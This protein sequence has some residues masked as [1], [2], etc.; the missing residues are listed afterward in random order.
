MPRHMNM[1]LIG[2][3]SCFVQGEV[4]LCGGPDFQTEV[5]KI[6]LAVTVSRFVH[7]NRSH[8]FRLSCKKFPIES[9]EELD[10][11]SGD[12]DTKNQIPDLAEALRDMISGTHQNQLSPLKG[13]K[14][15]GGIY[16]LYMANAA[17]ASAGAGSNEAARLI[18]DA[19]A[20]AEQITAGAQTNADR[21][22][23]AAQ[24][25]AQAA[26]QR[27]QL[28]GGNAAC[29]Y[30]GLRGDELQIQLPGPLHSITCKRYFKGSS[31]PTRDVRERPPEMLFGS[32]L[33]SIA[34]FA[35]ASASAHSTDLTAS[36]RALV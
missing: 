15:D 13:T 36:S 27:F 11:L 14:F 33:S 23:T 30:C 34:G 21:I 3:L 22:T 2:P 18:R 12:R 20:R 31:K 32:A 29:K 25:D 8:L 7:P 16:A 35:S 19:T 24:T 26:A 5:L 6:P 28:D 17:A 10:L 1:Q 9:N 4:T